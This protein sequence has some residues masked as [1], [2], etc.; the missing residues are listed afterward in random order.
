M[1]PDT[2]LKLEEATFFLERLGENE[3][4]H[5]FRFYLSAYL[6]AFN[7]F[8]D[9]MHT[10]YHGVAGFDAW[11]DPT[12]KPRIAEGGDLRKF[13]DLRNRVQHR[14][15]LELRVDMEDVDFVPTHHPNPRRP[16]FR[17]RASTP[18]RSQVLFPFQQV[19]QERGRWYFA[20]DSTDTW[21]RCDWCLDQL[22]AIAAD[23]S[24]RFG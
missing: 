11:Y 8:F 9:V 5:E 4:K 15:A 14:K 12:V 1:R 21:S 18:G 3:G 13:T 22:K 16:R 2:T 20:G 17:A 19:K 7:G 10:E 6:N 24:T 23:C